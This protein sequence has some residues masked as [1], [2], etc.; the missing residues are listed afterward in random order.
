MSEKMPTP[1]DFSQL[2][3]AHQANYT[4]FQAQTEKEVHEAIHAALRA[5]HYVSLYYSVNENGLERTLAYDPNHKKNIKDAAEQVVLT[6]GEIAQHFSRGVQIGVVDGTTLPE[7]FKNALAETNCDR[8]AAIP[9]MQDVTILS[10]LLIGAV[11]E[12]P[13]SE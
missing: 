6:Q 12:Q 9:V 4:V 7:A 5:C 2:I 8:Y 11:T 13:L 10:V 3:Q 1:V